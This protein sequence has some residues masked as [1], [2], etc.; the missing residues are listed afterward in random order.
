MAERKRDKRLQELFDKKIP[1]Y[2]FSKLSTINECLYQ[3][4]LAYILKQKGKDSCYGVA[5]TATH[6]VLE[7]IINNEATESDLLPT[8]QQTLE[9]LEI[10]GLPFPKDRKGGNAVR[11]GWIADMEHFCKTF[12][13]PKGKFETESFFLY[14]TDE[15]VY[16]QGYIDLIQLH[17]DG[18]ISILDWKTSG[19][20]KGEEIKE[21]GRQLVIYALA[22]EQEGFDIKRIAWI[23]L[24][25]VEVRFIG[26]KT[27]RSA[28]E[29][30]ISKVI[31]RKN[32]VTELDKHIRYKLEKLGKDE[33]DIDFIMDKAK[34]DNEIPKEVANEFKV[35]PYVMTYDLTEEVKQECIDYINDTVKRWGSLNKN[36]A[37]YPPRKFT[38][39]QK[40]GKEVEDTFFC[41]QLCNYRDTCK[42]IKEFNESRLTKPNNED[43]D[44]FG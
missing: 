3:A 42:H 36:E 13:R 38:R 37:E 4:Y 44:L 1:V 10:L 23:M 33:L 34:K 30:N 41:N 15:D 20:Y 6:D 27:V 5:G 19:M 7:K 35:L 31:E 8:I 21:H 17:N 18:T 9:E 25:Y 43:E 2:S 26:K 39:L 28:N 16:L 29:T 14:K 24:K 22:K 12:T 32:L 40:N 11:D